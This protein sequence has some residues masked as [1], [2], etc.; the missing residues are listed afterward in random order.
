[1]L[2]KVK[3]WEREEIGAS[4]SEV[5]NLSGGIKANEE[6]MEKLLSAYLDDDV[7]KEVYLK[8]KDVLMR[9]L[10][11]L[12]E[13]TKDFERGRKNWVEPLREWILDTKQADF[14]STSDN[15][16]EIK[17]LV[18]KI[19][20]NPRVRDKSAHFSPPAPSQSVAQL[21]HRMPAPDPSLG[22][23][24]PLNFA[25]VSFCGGERIRTSEEVAPLTP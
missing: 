1:M 14:L 9:A 7:P 3:I 15:L 19:G 24:R 8:R 17:A 16:H 12:K 6:R 4:Q 18:Q 2:D 5:Q 20:T 25:E 23:V 21:R 13:Q 10:A 22:Q 11:A